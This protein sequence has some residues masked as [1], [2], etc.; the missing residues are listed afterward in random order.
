MVG[1]WL[2]C[3]VL[4][5]VMS[6]EDA[7]AAASR[8]CTD[9]ER[10]KSAN[11]NDLWSTILQSGKGHHLA[12]KT[13]PIRGHYSAKPTNRKPQI[14]HLCKEVWSYNSVWPKLAR[15]PQCIRGVVR[16]APIGQDL[17]CCPLIG[18]QGPSSWLQLSNITRW[19]PERAFGRPLYIYFDSDRQI[20]ANSPGQEVT[21]EAICHQHI[22]QSEACFYCFWPISGK[23]S[24][25]LTNERAV[26]QCND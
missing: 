1:A 25:T 8:G 2:Y 6:I 20:I 23:N 17:E 14:A 22:S 9:E 10:L 3:T 12:V 19:C 4:H 16:S 18:C 26:S 24:V 11:K 21:C 13:L 15:P 7:T 5:S